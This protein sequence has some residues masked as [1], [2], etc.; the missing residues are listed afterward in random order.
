M[1]PIDWLPTEAKAR[2]PVSETDAVR[3]WLA[4]AVCEGRTGTGT[5]TLESCSWVKSAVGS[6]V[7]GSGTVDAGMNS[8]AISCMCRPSTMSRTTFLKMQVHRRAKHT[9]HVSSL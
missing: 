5:G 1:P 4:P 2:L 6:A 9:G 3:A 8:T 7:I